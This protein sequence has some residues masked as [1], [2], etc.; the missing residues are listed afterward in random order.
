[1]K[2]KNEKYE[3]LEMFKVLLLE[4]DDERTDICCMC[5]RETIHAKTLLY[6]Q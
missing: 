6:V 2:V 3:L 1:M 4:D 5:V